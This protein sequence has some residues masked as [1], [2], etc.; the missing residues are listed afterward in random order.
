MNFNDKL[1]NAFE[2]VNKN[3]SLL[4]IPV[5]LDILS[6]SIYN[7]VLKLNFQFPNKFFMIKLGIM[8]VPPSITYFIDN[9]PSLTINYNS[10][11]G[12]T[13]IINELT[14]LSISFLISFIFIHSF[15]TSAYM[16][17]LERSGKWTNSL[18]TFFKE[19]NK[20]WH[21][22]FIL[23]VVNASVALLGFLS[24]SFIFL[25]IPLII[26]FYLQYSFVIDKTVSLKENL[27]IA[28]SALFNNLGFS[29]K[30]GILCGIVLSLCSSL[31]FIF[32]NMG[33]GGI[34]IAIILMD[35]AGMVINKTVIE[36]YRELRDK[37]KNFH[38]ESSSINE[39]V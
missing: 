20:T 2:S 34:I 15:L 14:P 37:S 11:F 36:S 3:L 18:S 5:C 1:E 26:L 24:Y 9:F 17:S 22:F 39:L 7:F 33:Y 10:T 16:S 13:G 38:E 25:F 21:K 29:I 35:Y 28:I 4:L 8:P 30:L 32:G 23:E 12:S 31:I 27:S 19:G 6:I